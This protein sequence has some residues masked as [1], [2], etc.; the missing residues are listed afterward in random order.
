MVVWAEVGNGPLLGIHILLVV[1]VV[2]L[3]HVVDAVAFVGLTLG[4]HMG[5]LS[6]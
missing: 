5:V 2:L 1:A 6:Q 3:G 4:I